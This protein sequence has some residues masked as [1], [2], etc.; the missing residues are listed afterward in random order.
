MKQG[1][2]DRSGVTLVELMVAMA[3]MVTLLGVAIPPRTSTDLAGSEAR[4]LVADGMRVR[5]VA[6]TQWTPA[7]VRVHVP[8]RRWRCY[9]DNGSP[10]LGPD[11]DANGWR[12]LADGVRFV[13]ITQR[14]PNF[15]FLPNGRTYREASI[16]ITD[17]TSSW[18]VSA[19]ALSGK[20]NSQPTTTP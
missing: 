14:D 13:K 9:R 12:R 10:I 5:S 8:S 2:N 3:I 18:E 17:N 16:I 6:Q 11:S 7:G 19:N 20:I 4:R 1:R 15:I